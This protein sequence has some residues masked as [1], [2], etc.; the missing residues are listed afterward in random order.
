MGFTFQEQLTS[1]D[2]LSRSIDQI[3]A[4]GRTAF[5]SYHFWRSETLGVC[6]ALDGDLQSVEV[7][8]DCYHEALVHPA[9]LLHPAPKR[10]L[11][12]GGGEGATA[13]QILRHSC[14]EEVVMCDIDKEFVDL[15]RVHIP[16]W[17]AEAWDDPR[18]KVYYEDIVQYIAQNK[19]GFDVVIGDLVDLAGDNPQVEALYGQ[20]F[21]TM[22]AS[23]MNPGA[24]MATQASGLYH[25]DHQRH[26]TIRGNLEAAF[27]K[28]LSYRVTIPSFF[29][30]WGFAVTGQ[31]PIEPTDLIQLFTQRAQDRDLQMEAFDPA[32]L[33]ATFMLPPEVRKLLKP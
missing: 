15:C 33:A 7:D 9:M 17:G 22:L 25:A 18:L 21:F 16:T 14:V 10:V 2:T 27:G 4:Q 26:L 13:R 8:V 19:E 11:I 5:Q 6:I 12:C 3:L 20:D 23:R 32:S 1:N 31:D 29:A 30:P 24:L 28:V